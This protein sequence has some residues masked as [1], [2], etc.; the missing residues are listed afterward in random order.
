MTCVYTKGDNGVPRAVAFF[1]FVV[2]RM[3]MVV[4]LVIMVPFEPHLVNQII[5]VTDHS[6]KNDNG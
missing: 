3:L 6:H 5:C 1:M 4:I 2:G